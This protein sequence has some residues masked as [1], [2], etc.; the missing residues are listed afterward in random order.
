MTLAG[1]VLSVTL[2]A[3]PR[4]ADDDPRR[5]LADALAA[6]GARRLSH[7]G[8]HRYTTT[9]GRRTRRELAAAH[10]SRPTTVLRLW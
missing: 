3:L 10:A 6:V 4:H 2:G 1:A 7:P 8:N 5:W 9:L